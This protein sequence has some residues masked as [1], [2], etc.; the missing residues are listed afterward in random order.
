VPIFL[1]KTKLVLAGK[2]TSE[3]AKAAASALDRHGN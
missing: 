1:M 3:I 2:S